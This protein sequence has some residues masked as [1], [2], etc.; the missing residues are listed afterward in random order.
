MFGSVPQGEALDKIKT[1]PNYKIDEKIFVNRLPDVLKR[2]RKEAM[3]FETLREWLRK[4]DSRIPA[5]HLPEV[6]PDLAEFTKPSDELK[7]IWLGHSTFLLNMSGKI[8][9][10]DPGLSGSAAPFSFMVKRFQLPA[11]SLEE[12]PKI[13]IIVI[14]HDHYDHLD[15][16]SMKFF[17]DQ[18]GQ[19]QVQFLT[20]L[21]VGSHLVSWGIDRSRITELDWWESH[22]VGDLKFTATPAQ[23]FSGRSPFDENKTLWASWVMRSSKHNIYFSGDSGY[24]MHFKTIGDKYGPF[25]VAFIEN[26]QY[27]MKWHAVHAMPE[28]SVQAYFDLRAKRFFPV[29]WGVFVLALHSWREPVDRLLA[30]AKE[31]GVNIVTPKFGQIVTLN[32]EY[33]NTEWWLDYK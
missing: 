17:A 13:D 31:R 16:I 30:L 14:S 32:D 21:G 33:K 15:A 24:D 29:H 27:N 23:H 9:L 7:V 2:M 8:I 20:P 6:K 5:E 12:L 18:G 1:S 3:S 22:N 19:K 4:D 10:V 11:L 26:G 25:D 28:E